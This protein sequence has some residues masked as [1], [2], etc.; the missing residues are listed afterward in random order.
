MLFQPAVASAQSSGGVGS[1]SGAAG[2]YIDPGM[3]AGA[4]MGATT[5]VSGGFSSSTGITTGVTTTSGGTGPTTTGGGGGVGWGSVLFVAGVVLVYFLA[6]RAMR[7]IG[8][9]HRRRRR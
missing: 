7:L 6:G 2:R 5:T 9:V 8:A 4:S 1:A 3:N